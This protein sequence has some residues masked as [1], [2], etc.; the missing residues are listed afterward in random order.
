MLMAP[1]LKTAI[2]RRQ[3][4]GKELSLLESQKHTGVASGIGT[5]SIFNWF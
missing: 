2:K 4:S 3:A 1:E 5:E